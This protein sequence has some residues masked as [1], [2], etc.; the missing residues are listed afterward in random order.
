MTDSQTGE[1]ITARVLAQI[2]LEHDPLKLEV[3]PVAFLHRV[4]RANEPLIREFMDRYFNQ[5]L[6]AYL[7]SQRQLSDYLRQ[8]MGLGL[9]SAAGTDWLRMMM[10]PFG[11]I[12]V[13]EG[14]LADHPARPG[15]SAASEVAELRKL[16]KELRE[17][18][19]MPEKRKDRESS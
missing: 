16:V 17:Q 7:D 14:A 19:A 2:I 9:P 15:D 4:I 1:D 6:Q 13:S 3:F 8:A 10:R 18:V 5:F 11:Q 12:A